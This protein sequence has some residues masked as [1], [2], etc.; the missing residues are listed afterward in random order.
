[1]N[2]KERLV[3]I[4]WAKA[5]LIY[6]MVVGH[7]FPIAW[8]NQLIYAFHMPAF[9]ILSGF[10]YRPHHWSKTLKSFLIPIVFFSII[11][12]IIYV[13]PRLLKGTF[14]SDRLLDRIL[15][16][17]WGGRSGISSED[18]IYCFPGVWFLIALFLCR[19]FLGD[20]PWFSWVYKYKYYVMGGI[21]LFL[22]LE[23][24]ILSSNPFL[25]YKFY[26]F[27]PSMPFV[28]FGCCLKDRL[29]V[30][31]I[32]LS[33][34]FLLVG[35]FVGLSFINGYCNILEYQFGKSYL[36]FFANACFGSIA[37]FSICSFF[38]SSF[39]IQLFS[40][41]TILVLAMNFNLKVFFNLFLGKLG[42]N[43]V[44]ADQYLFPWFLGIIIMVACYYPIKWLFYRFP[45][46]LGK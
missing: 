21:L 32:P 37:L 41:G 38:H 18:F 46:L 10:L 24:V 43:M 16:P 19:L 40:I 9:F 15:V 35:I 3:W 29:C 11:N 6:L 39:V 5:I 31:N 34:I 14:S 13:I 23:P 20:I 26:R 1:M 45:I 27:V 42:W 8:E 44:I 7:C 17:Y 22:T 4:D 2:N 25:V 36:I 12:F 30:S 28:L 33:A